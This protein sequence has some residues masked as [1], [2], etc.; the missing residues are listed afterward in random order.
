[1]AIKF[2]LRDSGSRDYPIGE[3]TAIGRDASCQIILSGDTLV[4]RR[5]ALVWVQ[6]D[7]LYVRDES[8]S[9][10]TFV[11]GQRLTPNAATPLRA[12]DKLAVGSTLFLALSA[13]EAPATVIAPRP[14][15][16]AGV[17]PATAAPV[18]PPAAAAPAAAAASPAPRRRPAFW[19]ACAVAGVIVLLLLWGGAGLL[20]GARNPLAL[21]GLPGAGTSTVRPTQTVLSTSVM[22]PLLTPQQYAASNQDLAS[23]V[24]ALN[25][26]EIDFVQAATGTAMRAPSLLARPALRPVGAPD[27]ESK[28]LNVAADAFQTATL[29]DRLSQTAAAQG[30]GSPAADQTASQYGGLARMAASLVID[31]QN[32][33]Q[34]LAQGTVTPKEAASTVA[35]YGARL[36]NPAAVSP[37]AAG[38]PFTPLL[39][40]S[41][42]IPRPQV[43]TADAVNQLS[44]QLGGNLDAWLAT[45]GVTVT[46]TLNVP[47]ASGAALVTSDPAAQVNLATAEGQKD[48][49][50]SRAAAEA[51]VEA[52]GGPVTGTLGVNT[53]P[54]GGSVEAIFWTGVAVA[55]PKEQKANPPQ[56]PAYSNGQASAVTTGAKPDDTLSTL[57]DIGTGGDVK[58]GAQTPVADSDAL[59]NLTIS[60]IAVKSVNVTGRSAGSTFEA[61]ATFEFDV[62]WTTSVIAPRLNL[63]CT[64]TNHFSINTASGSQHV[65]AKT[66]L[67]LY[68]GTVTAYCYATSQNGNALGSVAVN[69]LVGDAGGATQRAV[70]VE[71]DSANLD[72]TLTADAVNTQNVEST[73]AAA[74]QGALSTGTAVMG[75]QNALETEVAAQQTEEFAA[76]ITA[77]AHLTAVA[78]PPTEVTPSATPTFVPV[79]VETL[80]H[81]GNLFAVTTKT[82]L[83][84]NRLYQF[85]FSGQVFLINPDRAVLASDIDHVNGIKVPPSECLTLEGNGKAATISCGQGEI[86]QDP[87]GFNIVVTDLGPT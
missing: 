81:P 21:A 33:R 11:N 34:G 42:Q 56:L 70:Q 79:V 86:A 83:Q 46:K 78:V 67:I 41:A 66:S 69:I 37:A 36:W 74:T 22:P 55:S 39:P 72:L 35:E 14:V 23:A 77:I 7:T 12:G 63:D 32:A 1:M 28:L 4:S 25:Q 52:G 68:P 40:A 57:V 27:L 8:S 44:S 50:A 58:L 64:S 76:T 16:P 38:D 26:A 6:G 87:G 45:S 53:L 80:A 20:I 59:V 60:N 10:G 85:C 29:A 54:A 3:A 47:A 17:A 43:L 2:V 18:A 24:A 31:A 49:S 13:A 62:Q 84:P 71:T 65:S 61:D 30:G 9:N 82:V 5:H 51:I 75:T 15:A 19:M 73:N 48:A